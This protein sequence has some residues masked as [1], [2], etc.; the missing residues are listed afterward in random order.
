MIGMLVFN[1]TRREY[2][3]W[4]NAP[5][6]FRQ[7]NGVRGANFQ[8]RITVEFEKF[9]RG[10]EQRGGFFRLGGAQ[11]WRAIS[12]SFA[13]RADDKMGFAPGLGF[14]SMIAPQPN[15]MSSGCA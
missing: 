5:Q 8:M 4:A 11:F 6:N 14:A 7:F 15:S 12:S 3:T 9:N 13:A 1:Q 2:D 10:T